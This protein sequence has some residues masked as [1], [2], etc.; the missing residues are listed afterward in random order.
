MLHT[1][2]RALN[3]IGISIA[4]KHGLRAHEGVYLGLQGPNLETPAEYR[5]A[6]IIGADVIGM[7]TV[8]EVIVAAHMSLPILVI[9]LVSNKCFPI[10]EIGV[11]TLESVIAMAQEATPKMCGMVKEILDRLSQTT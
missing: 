6:N 3:Q 5:F 4:E 10:E 9:S 7:S 11:T 1:Y 2:D 8:S